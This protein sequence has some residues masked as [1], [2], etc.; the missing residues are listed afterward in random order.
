[1]ANDTPEVPA[2]FRAFVGPTVNASQS[3]IRAI[4]RAEL[5]TLRSQV[6]GAIGRTSDR[7]SKIHLEDVLVRIDNTLDPK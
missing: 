7:L 2:Q 3:D 5:K 6:Q 1:M 4:V